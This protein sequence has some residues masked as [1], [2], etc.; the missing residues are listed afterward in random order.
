MAY[1]VKKTPYSTAV[2]TSRIILLGII[3]ITTIMTLAANGVYIITLVKKRIL[4][5]PSN[6][7]LGALALSDLLVGIVTNPTW[8]IT[9][10]TT[11]DRNGTGVVENVNN[12]VMYFFILL[13]LLNIVTVS[14]DRYIAIFYPYWYRANATCKT[15][16]KAAVAVLA[17]SIIISIPLGMLAVIQRTIASYIYLSF[18]AISLTAACYCNTRI[19]HLIRSKTREVNVVHVEPNDDEGRQSSARVL[20]QKNNANVIIIITVLFIF[21]YMPSTIYFT[22]RYLGISLNRNQNVLCSFWT[23]LLVLLNSSMNP[24]VY[25]FRM[26]SF[27]MAFKEIFFRGQ[28]TNGQ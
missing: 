16:I 10:Y 8:M 1:S 6:M 3:P 22:I 4:H 24:I 21:C 19:F 23:I 25:F 14:A 9:V 17:T 26:R 11:L 7:L 12:L 13:S 2:E 15:H 20:Q 5:K 18:I 27:R 28:N